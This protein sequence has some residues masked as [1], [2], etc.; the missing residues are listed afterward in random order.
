VPVTVAGKMP[1]E[2]RK[3]S[4]DEY[5]VDN[6]ARLVAAADRLARDAGAEVVHIVYERCEGLWSKI[7]DPD[8][9]VAAA[10]VRVSR[11]LGGWWKREFRRAQR[12]ASLASTV[13]HGPDAADFER[14]RRVA[15]AVARLPRRQREC[16][17]LH[18]YFDLTQVEIARRLDLHPGTVERHLLRANAKLVRE[19]DE[20]RIP[21]REAKINPVRQEEV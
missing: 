6:Y 17:V 21:T 7:D 2:P 16:V 19:L 11:E 10:I 20:Y 14:D 15:A 3:P 1:Q 4:R 9:Y 12:A 18:H 8:A 5:F 13:E